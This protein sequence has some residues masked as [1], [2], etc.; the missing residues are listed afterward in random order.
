MEEQLEIG[1]DHGL[2]YIIIL[3]VISLGL[4]IF[5]HWSI[6]H[7]IEELLIKPV[8]DIVKTSENIGPTIKPALEKGKEALGKFKLFSLIT[9]VVLS[10]LLSAIIYYS[11][12]LRK[13]SLLLSSEKKKLEGEQTAKNVELATR[14]E[15]IEK[16]KTE[17]KELQDKLQK[18]IEATSNLK[19]LDNSL[20]KEKIKN[21]LEGLFISNKNKLVLIIGNLFEP[22]INFINEK[23]SEHK[24]QVY[25]VKTKLE[26]SEKQAL[27]NIFTD[28]NCFLTSHKQTFENVWF[29]NDQIVLDIG[30]KHI[31]IPFGVE[32]LEHLVSFW[33]GNAVKLSFSS[34]IDYLADVLHLLSEKAINEININGYAYKANKFKL[35]L[36][37][38][39]AIFKTFPAKAGEYKKEITSHFLEFEK[40]FSLRS[41]KHYSCV[42][43]NSPKYR[44]EFAS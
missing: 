3:L 42:A 20:D 24:N 5:W 33:R 23:A 35:W 44:Y 9:T 11:L 32:A 36:E 39:T 10:L 8:E 34:K 26:T 27:Y 37:Q 40:R 28:T 1:K 17:I 29:F 15:E 21:L 38:P 31:F 19:I 2:L 16:H 25:L 7:S 12:K 18:E 14:R 6:N 30:T 43:F 4:T 41:T 22:I 13:K